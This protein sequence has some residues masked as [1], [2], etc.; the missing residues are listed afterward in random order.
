MMHSM[1]VDSYQL[2]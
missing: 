2:F 1:P